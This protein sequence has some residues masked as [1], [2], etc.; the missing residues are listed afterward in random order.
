MLIE[1]AGMRKHISGFKERDDMFVAVF[2]RF[3]RFDE[4]FANKK[5]G[6]LVAAFG[7]MTS[8]FR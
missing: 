7:K 6:F 5:D 2:I 8:F 3:E 1:K 4:A